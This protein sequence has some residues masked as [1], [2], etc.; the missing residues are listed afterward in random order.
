MVM[1]NLGRN[2]IR[3]EIQSLF[4]SAGIGLSSTAA[5]AGDTSLFGGGATIDACDATSGW[6]AT[7]D[8]NAVT[9]NTTSGEYKEGTGCLNIPTTYSAGT[10][11]WTKTISSTDLS[12]TKIAVWFYID[13]VG[14]LE[15]ASDAV[16]LVLGT[17]GVTNTNNYDF[18]RDGL[19]SGWNSLVLDADSPD[20]TGGSGATLTTIDRI[21]IIVGA[22]AT[23]STNEM[24][25]DFWRSYVSGGLGI[26][27]SL[28]APVVSTGNYYVK[29]VH[30]VLV[31]ESNG[32]DITEA[33][34]NNGSSLLSRMVFA[35]LSKGSNTELQVDKFYYIDQE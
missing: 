27:D 20:G 10:A 24:R 6:A 1:T 22:E 11:T 34:D 12:S 4:S 25:M 30:S 26:A 29:T 28:K 31:T 14:D 3:D 8:G 23:Q 5:N 9:L 13:S 18:S 7:G 15:D 32:L 2:L 21:R 19:V 16:S 33:G 17:G 35:T